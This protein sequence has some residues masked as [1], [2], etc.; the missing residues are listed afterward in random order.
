MAR[1]RIPHTVLKPDPTN[2]NALIP[3]SGASIEVRKRSD[4][5]LATVY[6]TEG[7]GGTTANPLATDASGR[8]TAWVDRGAYNLVVSGSGVTGYTMPW[9]ST[10]G[11]DATIDAPWLSNLSLPIGGIIA[12][13]GAADVGAW[14]L[15]DGRAVSRTTYAALFGV[16]GTT[17]GVGDGST[18]FNLP[19][20]KGRSPMG[21]GTGS[22]L[23]ARALGAKL[24]EELH[25]LT[26]AELPALSFT[27][28]K[29]TD[30][31]AGGWQGGTSGATLRLNQA[32]AT[33]TRGGGGAHNV[34]HPVLVTNFA[35]RAL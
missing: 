20:L 21:A 8:V 18:T 28:D 6:T 24:G 26:E 16:I 29:L 34:V 9:E 3:A 2:A 12:F 5:T 27:Y 15:C 35:I 1:A 22:G 23:T 11:G 13:A 31:V 14:L 33:N 4:N 25:L 19:D 10:P 7:G 17:F 30:N 32:T